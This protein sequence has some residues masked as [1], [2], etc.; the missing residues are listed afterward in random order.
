[1][2]TSTTDRTTETAA[3]FAA[4]VERRSGLPVNRIPDA[5]A[6]CMIGGAIM[7][8]S[9]HGTLVYIDPIGEDEGSGLTLYEKCVIVDRGSEL[10]PAD[11]DA[12]GLIPE[13]DK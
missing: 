9:S 11:E 2:T 1:M 4:R 7:C 13:D 12:V 8:R 5:P 10:A 6:D 3:S